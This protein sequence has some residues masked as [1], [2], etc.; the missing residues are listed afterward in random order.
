MVQKEPESSRRNQT[1]LLANGRNDTYKQHSAGHV[2]VLL[3][4]PSVPGGI[5][6]QKCQT[7]EMKRK[8][9]MYLKQDI[10]MRKKK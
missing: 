2:H 5:E 10:I 6:E 9:K 4:N 7:V 1:K 3:P 8:S